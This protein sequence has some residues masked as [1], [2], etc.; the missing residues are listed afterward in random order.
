[1]QAWK[2]CIGPQAWNNYIAMDNQQGKKNL[3]R[4]GIALKRDSCEISHAAACRIGEP[5]PIDALAGP[6]YNNA[7]FLSAAT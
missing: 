2:L 6:L 7:S 5:Q 1:V 4:V 3:A